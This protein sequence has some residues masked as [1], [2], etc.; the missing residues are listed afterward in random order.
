M[1]SQ[2]LTSFTRR[3]RAPL[4][5]T[6]VA[7]GMS[8]GLLAAPAVQAQ[9]EA[10]LGLSLLPVASVV[11][12]SSEV[13]ELPLALSAHGAALSVKAVKASGR[14]VV[15]VLERASDAAQASVELVGDAVGAS[16]LAV[17]A[18]VTSTVLASGV[19]LSVAGEVLAFI[20]NALGRALLH[21]EVLG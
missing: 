4:A 5:R 18:S 8:L 11:G 9:S 6:A 1:K 16:A 13:A 3:L 7:L 20:P 17:G 2:Y 12:A 19:V 21:N 10:S 15:V 14:G